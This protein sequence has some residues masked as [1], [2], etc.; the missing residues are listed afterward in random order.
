[1]RQEEKKE[2]DERNRLKL[3][4]IRE[5]RY[6][7]IYHDIRDALEN[8]HKKY[9][10]DGRR[11]ILNCDLLNIDDDVTKEKNETKLKEVKTG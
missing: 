4:K 2:R 8:A 6:D 11:V 10:K 7:I 9:K 5:E 3:T 1:M